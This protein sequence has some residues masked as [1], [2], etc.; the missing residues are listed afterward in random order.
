MSLFWQHRVVLLRATMRRP[1]RARR[2]R[3]VNLDQPRAHHFLA[4]LGH[5]LGHT[6][7]L[8]M[9]VSS[10]SVMK[11]TPLALPGRWRASTTTAQSTLCGWSRKPTITLTRA[12]RT[13][14]VNILRSCLE[15]RRSFVHQ[16]Y[17]SASITVPTLPRPPNDW[18]PP[19]A[20]RIMMN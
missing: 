9:P 1:S 10:S 16:P 19:T 4:E 18:T 8:A 6:T 12:I 3:A 11:T 17:L 2:T 15:H 7:M 5:H 14:Q 13:D 20:T